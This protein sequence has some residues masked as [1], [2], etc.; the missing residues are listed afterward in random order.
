[1]SGKIIL[2]PTTE[3]ERLDIFARDKTMFLVKFGNG[4]KNI[5]NARCAEVYRG[6]MR[7]KNS[8]PSVIS[9]Q[10]VE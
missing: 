7:K 1:M 10:P 9:V 4:G 5:V 6:K 8:T 3:A 2:V